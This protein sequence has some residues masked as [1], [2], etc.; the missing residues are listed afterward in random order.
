MLF[1]SPDPSL[2]SPCGKPSPARTAVGSC[3]LAWTAL[4]WLKQA[5]VVRTRVVSVRVRRFIIG[6]PFGSGPAVGGISSN[7]L[8]IE[9]PGEIPCDACHREGVSLS[10][11]LTR[12]SGLVSFRASLQG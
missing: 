10:E 4:G 6:L 3:F 11:K 8:M 5:A 12:A 2:F 9:E 7:T 1:R